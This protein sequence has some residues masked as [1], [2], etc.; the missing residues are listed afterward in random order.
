MPSHL[1]LLLAFLPAADPQ[2]IK[3]VEIDRKDPVSYNK[4]IEPILL[5]KC[6]SCHNNLKKEGNLDL[7]AYEL[8]VKG[9][10][11]GGPIVA[12]NSGGSLMVKSC[13]KTEKPFMPP[14]S[15]APLSPEELA[16]IKMWIDQGAK[17]PTGPRDK[18]KVVVAAPPAGVQP[19]RGIAVSPDKSAV[20]ASRGSQ[21][22]VYDAG[23]G[24][25]VRSLTDPDLKGAD[26]KPLAAAHLS[27]VESLAYSPNGKFI[28]SGGYQEVILWDAQ[29]GALRQRI[30]G[31]ADRVVALAFSNDG[32]LLATGGGAPTEDGELKVF[33]SDTGKLSFEVKSAH[34]DTVYG[35]S[36]S[37]D[38]K[39]L[40]SCGADKFVKTFEVPSGKLLKSFEG[41]TGHVLDVGWKSDGKLLASCGAD[42]A[43]KVWDYEKGEQARTIALP[44]GSKEL[45]RLVF[46]GKK[47]EFI[48]CTG[49]DQ[50]KV[51]NVD[52][53]GN[54]R[55]FGG[56]G[57]DF[58]YAV[59]VSPDGLAVAVGGEEGVVRLFK[60]DDG[61][62][63]KELLPPGV[64]PP[65]KK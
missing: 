33:D 49:D 15:E 8:L 31:F 14:K 46:V 47:P 52:N 44:M 65:K 51:W 41:H 61:K 28:A 1:S 59:G 23:S 20:A 57:K 38:D 11:R 39:I 24:E 26:D 12:G 42:K 64:T 18:P 13:G 3:V 6:A 4:D 34:S 37:P 54:T 30:T 29:T 10:K 5:N 56:G 32:K 36:F 16:L 53:G 45:T 62:L 40:A 63:I 50:V 60:G 25:Y 35:V 43:I 22:H 58:L 7:S 21:I 9:G 19:V 55:N 48:T 2:P 27:L 17:A